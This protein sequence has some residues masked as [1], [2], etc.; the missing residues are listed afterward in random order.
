MECFHHAGFVQLPMNSGQMSQAR[1]GQGA[2]LVVVVLEEFQ[3]KL[4]QLF[5]VAPVVE[6][7]ADHGIERR[8]QVTAIQ[9]GSNVGRCGGRWILEDAMLIRHQCIVPLRRNA[10]GSGGFRIIGAGGSQTLR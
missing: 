9:R 6:G 8:R 3:V 2:D 5:P 4:L 1:R 7:G 10:D